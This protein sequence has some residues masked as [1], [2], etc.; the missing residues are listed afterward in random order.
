MGFVE[1]EVHAR[2]KQAEADH[3]AGVAIDAIGLLES[4]VRHECDVLVAI[5]APAEV[6]CKRI[7]AREGISEEY[8]WNRVKAQKDESYFKENCDYVL[9]NDST[10][11]AFRARAVELFTKVL[12]P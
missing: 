10:E 12:N 11:E 5:T 1:D 4:D 2:M 7:M 3:K 8:A 9:P 6:R